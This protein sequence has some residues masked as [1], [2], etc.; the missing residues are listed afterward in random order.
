MGILTGKHVNKRVMKVIKKLNT[1]KQHTDKIRQRMNWDKLCLLRNQIGRYSSQIS[2]NL[3]LDCITDDVKTVKIVCYADDT[4]LIVE[5]K[6]ATNDTDKFN[7]TTL[8]YNIKISIS[9]TNA[10]GM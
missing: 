10:I 9:K 5:T 8:E 1:K 3:I 4:V 6:D 2:F 7:K